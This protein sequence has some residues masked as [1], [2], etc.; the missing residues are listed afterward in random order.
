VTRVRVRI[1]AL[2][3]TIF[4]FCGLANP[5]IAQ[6]DPV[7]VMAENSFLIEEA[8]NQ[9]PDEVQHVFAVFY[10]NDKRQR[11]WTFVFTQEWP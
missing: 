4:L 1:K 10:S 8:Y 7:E 3:V 6:K 5:V 9:E 2:S 11:G